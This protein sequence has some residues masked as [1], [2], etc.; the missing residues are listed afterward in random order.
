MN[1]KK[2]SGT[3]AIVG[4]LSLSVLFSLA[5]FGNDAAGE[6]EEAPITSAR[7]LNHPDYRVGVNFTGAPLAAVKRDLPDAKI[8][9]F[10]VVDGYLAVQQGR[11]DAYAYDRTQMEIAISNGLKGVVLLPQNIGESVQ[12][13]VGLSP[14]SKI[15]GLREKINQF[16]SVL[17]SDGTLEDMYRRWVT[18]RSAEMPEIELPAS[19]SFI[20][21]VGTT[22]LVPPYSYYAGNGLTGYD[23][24]LARRFAAWLGAGVEFTVYD[25]GGI[26]AAA[27]AGDVDCVMANLNITPERAEKISFSDVLY[28]ENIAIMVRDTAAKKEA[29]TPSRRRYASLDELKDKRLGVLTG[30]V[31]DSILK[32]AFPSARVFFFDNVPDLTTALLSGKIDA[33]AADK[34]VAAAMSARDSRFACI[35]E[36]LNHYETAFFAAKNGNKALVE[37]LN[38]FIRQLRNEGTLDKLQEIWTGADDSK[39]IIPPYETFP[40]LKGTLKMAHSGQIFPFD[41]I[42]EGK[43]VGYDID[44]LA[45]FCQARGYRLKPVMMSFSAMLQAVQSHQCDIGGGNVTVTPERAESVTFTE[46]IYQSGG[47]LVVLND[48]EPSASSRGDQGGAFPGGKPTMWEDFISGMKASFEKTFIREGRWRLFVYGTGNTLLITVLSIVFG[49]ALGFG[50]Y[51]FCRGGDPAAGRQEAHSVGRQGADSV[52]S[53]PGGAGVFFPLSFNLRGLANAVTRFYVWLVQGMP[54]VVLLMILYYIVF[55]SLDIDAITVA[56]VAFTLTFG[57]AT[58]G[59]LCMGVGAIDIGQ[60]EAAY[61]LGYGSWRTFFRI[62]LPQALPHFM[63]AYRG[64]VA[65]LIKATAVVGYIAVQDVTKMGD[66]V[67]S[68]TYEAFFPLIA[69]AVIYFIMAGALNFL[70]SRIQTLIDPKRRKREDILRNIDVSGTGAKGA[71]SHD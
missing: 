7:Q 8:F 23:I 21:N 62:I 31:Y 48:T 61:A 45:R 64:N 69:V 42:K 2:F 3:W 16:L 14:A 35:P 50:L 65:A 9:D 6:A 43:I 30:S 28:T 19:P 25:Y 12:I 44:I 20:L 53:P 26:I 51:L 32:K 60:T 4:L 10:S 17:R 18:D 11:I 29:E 40:A 63:P 39:K 68:R 58:Y 67:R 54:M 57:A 59:M 5:G 38:T 15:K 52:G 49:T 34:P 33:F 66:I 24:E 37:E 36:P 13:A 46:P 70:I 56:V 1:C 71:D 27:T 22:G 55:S 41:Y 47:M